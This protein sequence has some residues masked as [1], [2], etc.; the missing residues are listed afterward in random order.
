MSNMRRIQDAISQ[1]QKDNERLQNVAGMLEIILKIHLE[2][3]EVLL[4]ENK[5]IMEQM[6]AVASAPPVY[7]REETRAEIANVLAAVLPPPLPSRQELFGSMFA[8]E[9][10]DG[11]TNR[12]GEF[13]EQQS[14]PTLVPV[15][16]ETSPLRALLEETQMVVIGRLEL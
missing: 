6:L 10:N 5:A 16:P 1:A 11:S 13:Q 7:Q 15:N 2:Q 4:K 9:Y 14:W 3:R 8:G 12:L